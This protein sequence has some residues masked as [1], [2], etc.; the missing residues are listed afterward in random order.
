MNKLWGILIAAAALLCLTACGSEFYTVSEGSEANDP[1]EVSQ[2]VRSQGQDASPPPSDSVTPTPDAAA[3][4][5]TP[6]PDS[7]PDSTVNLEVCR[8]TAC[9]QVECGASPTRCGGEVVECACAVSYDRCGDT[10]PNKCGHSCLSAYTTQ[11]MVAGKPSAWGVKWG[12]QQPYRIEDGRPV[13]RANGLEG[14]VY[15]QVPNGGPEDFYS[16]CP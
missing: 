4:V 15:Y 14:C 5:A 3:D 13:T 12:C 8:R 16:C 11:C 2:D 1:A 10:Q 6:P 9:L 7:A